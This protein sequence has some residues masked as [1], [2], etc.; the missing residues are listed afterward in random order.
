[1]LAKLGRLFKHR[2]SGDNAAI[3]VLPPE[4][5][6]RLADRVGASE[7]LHSG[8]IRI[9]VEAGLP[10][11]Y[12]RRNGSLQEIV[13]ARALT[14]FGKLRVWDT[15]HNNGVLIYLLLAERAIEIIADRGLNDKVNPEKWQTLVDSMRAAFKRGEFE[16]GL[17]QAVAE[18]SGLLLAH[19]PLAAGAD[20]LNELP[21]EPDLR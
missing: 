16:S 7:K 19:F 11:S 5:L 2:W 21:D 8:E 1:M 4:V 14:M 12:I 3:Q 13:H 17:N 9:C 10:W 15:A 6:K 20:N 18:V